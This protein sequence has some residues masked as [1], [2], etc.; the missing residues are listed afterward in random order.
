MQ[1]VERNYMPKAR[2]L[3]WIFFFFSLYPQHMWIEQRETHEVGMRVYT[4]GKLHVSRDQSLGSGVTCR[5]V[6]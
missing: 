1:L 5:F 3:I 4:C 2:T 6:N